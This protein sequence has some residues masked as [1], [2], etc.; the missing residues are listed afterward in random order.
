M[1]V[2]GIQI[3]PVGPLSVTRAIRFIAAG[4]CRDL[5]ALGLGR[6]LEAAARHRSVRGVCL[7]WA[8]R[9]GRPIAAAMALISRG[10]AAAVFLS[11]PSS[12]GVDP[13][14]LP[15]VV[16]AAA[17]EA[18]EAGAAFAQALVP[19]D[20][21]GPADVLAKAGFEVLADLMFMHKPLRPHPNMRIQDSCGPWEVLRFGQ[22]S[23]DEME[24]VLEASYIG[25]ADCPRLAG[26]RRTA[27]V[28]EC[29][30]GT[31]RFCPRWWWLA[32]SQGRS[33]GCILVN[34][35]PRASEAEVVYLGVVP[36]FRRRGLGRWLLRL[37]GDAAARAGLREISLAVDAA[38]TPAIRLYSEEG[39]SVAQRTTAHFFYR[40]PET[41]T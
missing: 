24:R 32:R 41:A 5:E 3:E 33:A 22:Y 27:D 7:W 2:Q 26:L 37:A 17:M 36:A 16:R 35:V 21:P 11:A 10:G 30:K 29:H 19:T 40:H 4:A 28:I 8:R 14:V 18:L 31:G 34:R 13:A 12:A 1:N 39:F 20:S 6:T 38:N 9:G 23:Q 25:S 15:A